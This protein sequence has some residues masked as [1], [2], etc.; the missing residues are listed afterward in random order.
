MSIFQTIKELRHS[1]KPV[2]AWNAGYPALQNEPDNL[3]LKRSLYWACYD[4]IKSVQSQIIHRKNKAPTQQEQE[5]VT[6]WI[7]C[8]EQLKL[9]M[10][11]EELDF[12]FFNLFKDNGEHYEAFVR[13]V[14]DNHSSLF[15]WPEDYTP[16]Q[17]EKHESP[18]QVVKQARMASKGWLT[19]RK[20]WNLSLSSL[21][22][23]LDLADQKAQDQDKTWMHYDYAKC[24]IGAKNYEAARDLVL[25]I[26][27][28]KASEFWAWGALA[29][30]YIESD[31]KRAIACYCKGLSA[32]KDPK[33]SVKMRG[34]LALLFARQGQCSE[35]SALLC[36]IADTYRNEGWTLKPEYED[37]MAQP[38]FDASVASSIN[39]NSYFS[40]HGAYADELLYD[41]IQDATGV[42]LSLHRS[43]KGFNVYLSQS[44][45]LSVRKGVF[46]GKGLPDRGDWVTITFA[47]TG[48]D[49][50]VL[51]AM[52]TAPISLTGVE[53]EV[54]EL[55]VHTKGFAF[56]CDTFVT[57]DLVVPEWNGAEVEVMKVWDI[58]PKKKERTWRAIKIKKSEAPTI[59]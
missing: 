4:G 44:Q 19:H 11:C 36:S 42:V 13:F 45:K 21:T 1:G 2:D 20:E 24:L 38:W 53:T 47:R 29:A 52:P 37:L 22:S 39:L 14:L 46:A 57:P 48:E 35:A 33:F 10:P 9:P 56:V 27:R 30:T 28:K 31:P 17:G 59:D 23:F 26:V 50:E 43:G 54:G 18:S 51:K 41:E 6:S 58:N 8:I 7:S 40:E 32:S 5:Y 3:F 34:G 49:T 16:Y 15:T 12:R 25:P 55:R